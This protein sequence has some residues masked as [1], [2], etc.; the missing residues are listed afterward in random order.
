MQ[1]RNGKAARSL[2][3]MFIL[4]GLGAMGCGSNEQSATSH[5]AG[6]NFLLDIPSNYWTKPSKAVGVE[7]APFVPQFI[8]AIAGTSNNLTATVGTAKGGVQDL[9]TQTQQASLNESQYP[10]SQIVLSQFP[11][12]FTEL[13]ETVT[14]S[15]TINLTSTLHDLT[16]ENVLPPDSG[17][18]NEGKFT[19]T[20]DLGELYKL[21][22]RIQPRTLENVC[23][24]LGAADAAC[25][26]CSFKSAQ[27]CLTL[28]AVQLGAKQV[29]TTVKQV[30]ALDKSCP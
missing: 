20:A 12:K 16:F 1:L 24:T 13:D 21:F 15:E 6:R 19:V 23:A 2:V 22:I 5:W 8:F 28:G 30:T 7:I 4:A 14:P 29:D 27:E 25:S 18:T 11:L 9:C 26:T 3:A 17:T 10:S